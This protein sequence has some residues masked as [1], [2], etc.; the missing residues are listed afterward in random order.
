MRI[1]V[2][3]YSYSRLRKKEGM[4]DAEL[5]R[6]VSS[7]GFDGIEFTEMRGGAS[8]PEAL[9]EAE[10][11]REE[12]EKLGLPVVSYSIGADLLGR[13]K[14]A[15]TERLMRCVDVA[16]AL[17]APVMRHDAA[18]APKKD[19]PRY[20]WRE[21]VK[22]MAPLI[23]EVTEYASSLGIRTCTENHGLFMQDSERVEALIREVGSPNY[24]WLVDVGNFLCAD[25]DPVRAVCTAAPYAFHVHVKDFLRKEWNDPDPGKGWLVTRGGSRIRGTI[26][27][28]GVVP[29]KQ[30]LDKIFSTGYDGFVSIE[31]EGLED[32]TTAVCEGLSYLRRLYPDNK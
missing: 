10:A 11:I 22:D 18:Y 3:S 1:A 19:V 26:V 7:Q 28:S 32:D 16:K 31:F 15:E 13:E 20:T 17:G 8:G 24:G 23:R 12:S 30:C 29:V 2:S 6:L 27:G 5:C 25:E 14:T 4:S 21:A 9:R